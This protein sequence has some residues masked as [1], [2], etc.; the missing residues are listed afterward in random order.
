MLWINTT[1]CNL[2]P[3]RL[4][5]VFL[6]LVIGYLGHFDAENSD[7]WFSLVNL[8]SHKTRQLQTIVDI[9]ELLVGF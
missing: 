5:H 1:E 8:F 6:S 9:T 7:H 2:H 4:G 3:G